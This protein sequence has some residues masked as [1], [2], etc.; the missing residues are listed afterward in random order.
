MDPRASRW[1][2]VRGERRDT[3]FRNIAVLHGGA[4]TWTSRESKTLVPGASNS[5]IDSFFISGHENV[6]ESGT[7]EGPKC[8][9][10]HACDCRGTRAVVP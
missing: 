6:A 8:A 2:S 10:D 4:M 5:R 1:P 9:G 3:D 7:V